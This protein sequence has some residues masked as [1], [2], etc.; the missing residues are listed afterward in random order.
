M[1]I[2]LDIKNSRSSFFMELLKSLDFVKVVSTFEDEERLKH[3]QD[4]TES[5]EDV[6]AHLNGRKKLQTAKELLDE[7]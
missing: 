5:F 7:L 6:D 2:I 1:K 4:I 3:V